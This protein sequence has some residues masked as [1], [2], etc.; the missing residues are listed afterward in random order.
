MRSLTL[1]TIATIVLSACSLFGPD[2]ES[3]GMTTLLQGPSLATAD[4]ES[5]VLPFAPFVTSLDEEEAFRTRYGISDPFPE[6]NYSTDMLVAIVVP[7]TASDPSVTID[8]IELI[9]DDRAT[10]TYTVS[11]ESAGLPTRYPLHVVRVRRSDLERRSI[12]TAASS[13]G[14]GS[15][16]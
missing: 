7:S 2:V 6:T 5:P 15:D 1:G 12:Q 8:A 10:V 4:N 11:G 14:Q 9:G 3:L 13:P 16:V